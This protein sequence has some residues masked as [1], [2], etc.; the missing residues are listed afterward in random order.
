[1]LLIVLGWSQEISFKTEQLFHH[2]MQQ[3]LFLLEFL[4]QH[5]LF[6]C[7]FKLTFSSLLLSVYCNILTNAL[8]NFSQVFVT[9]DNLQ[10]FWSKYFRG[11]LF[12]SLAF[13]DV[14]RLVSAYFIYLFIYFNVV[15]PLHQ[16]IVLMHCVAMGRGGHYTVTWFY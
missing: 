7:S 16:A 2:L 13:P 11:V 10:E 3:S 15:L 5:W 6:C 4:G 12:L 9:S 14:P 8:T 1:M